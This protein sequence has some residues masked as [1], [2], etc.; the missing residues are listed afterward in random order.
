MVT[1]A[2]EHLFDVT[3]EAT[4]ELGTTWHLTCRTCGVGLVFA[5]DSRVEAEAFM[6]GY[7][8][9]CGLDACRPSAL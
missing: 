5:A 9:A 2:T 1:T 3:H 7:A 6:R 4:N 8:S